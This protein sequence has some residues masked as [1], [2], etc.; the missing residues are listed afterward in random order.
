MTGLQMAEVISLRRMNEAQYDTERAELRETYGTSSREASAKRDQALATLFYRSGWTQEELAKKEGKSQDWVSLRVRFGRFLNF[1]T[2]VVSSEIV[3]NNLS[4]GKFR[5]FWAQTDAPDE[6]D[7]F[8]EVIKALQRETL[9]RQSNRPK[10]GSEIVA[11]FADGKWHALAKIAKALD[12]DEDHVSDT[13]CTMQR[14][15]GTYGC[16]AEKKIVGTHLEYRLF[17]TDKTV[18]ST[19]LVEKL[20]PILKGIEAQGKKT[21]ATWSPTAI[22]ILAH[23][24]RQLLNEWSE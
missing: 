17:K 1:T 10:I 18:T 22:A 16:R 15:R 19:E 21:L 23:Q 4:E 14:L 20:S 5:S 6:R 7:R 11:Q 9:I 8:H 3:P 24:L 2:T 12:T 13:L